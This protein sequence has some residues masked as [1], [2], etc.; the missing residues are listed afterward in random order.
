MMNC[1]SG[2]ESSTYSS[3]LLAITDQHMDRLLGIMDD[4]WMK[5]RDEFVHITLTLLDD[6]LGYVYD[7]NQHEEQVDYEYKPSPS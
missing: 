6:A 7:H 1:G 5:H 3:W 4:M 2:A